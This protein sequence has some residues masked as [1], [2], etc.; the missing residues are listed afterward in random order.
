MK[1]AAVLVLAASV[2]VTVAG[3]SHH[4]RHVQHRS[5]HSKAPACFIENES[6]CNGQNWRMSTCCKDVSYECRWNDNAANVMRC[7]KKKSLQK[8]YESDFNDDSTEIDSVAAINST[9]ELSMLLLERIQTRHENPKGDWLAMHRRQRVCRY[10]GR[11]RLRVS[12]EDLHPFFSTK[13][14]SLWAK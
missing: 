14:F 11:V 13:R 10:E 8:A 9:D 4:Y 5:Y 1:L 12:Q 3:R 6:Q 7:Q 2:V